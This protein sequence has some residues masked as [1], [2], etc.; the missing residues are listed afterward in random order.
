MSQDDNLIYRKDL[1]E[2]RIRELEEQSRIF[3]YK[4]N[5]ITAAFIGSVIAIF[6]ALLLGISLSIVYILVGLIGA[7]LGY[8]FYALGKYL[9][10]KN[11]DNEQVG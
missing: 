4:Q 6:A 11:K 2:E 10:E 1:T 7:G 5:C 9:E 3:R 8:G